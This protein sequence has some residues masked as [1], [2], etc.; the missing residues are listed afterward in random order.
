[1]SIS[2]TT[3]WESVNRGAVKSDAMEFL[4]ELI[5]HAAAST[6]TGKEYGIEDP[7]A[8]S[9]YTPLI[10][11]QGEEKMELRLEVG[12]TLR[13]IYRLGCRATRVG[14]RQSHFPN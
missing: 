7:P 6:D 10:E 5:C 14:T 12:N 3:V 11:F 8:L 2:A 13:E 4:L 1:M 9:H